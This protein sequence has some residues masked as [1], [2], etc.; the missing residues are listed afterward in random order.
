M[1]K[2]T[3][4]FLSETFS[5]GLFTFLG[6]VLGHAFGQTG[7]IIGA[8]MGGISGIVVVTILLSRVGLITIPHRKQAIVFGAATFI[9]AA[10][11]AVT[12]LNSPVIPLLSLLLVGTG[13]VFGNSY[14]AQEENKKPYRYALIGMVSLLPVFYFVAGSLVKYNLGVHHSFTLLDWFQADAMR[15]HYFNI[16]SPFIFTGGLSLGLVLNG[17]VFFN[18]PRL[19]ISFGGSNARLYKANLLLVIMSTLLL[20]TLVSYLLIENR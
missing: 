11:F 19:S 13:S 18:L 3:L 10:V 17:S 1:K 8:L 4:I 7:L 16:V 20:I 12:N 9:V 5:C 2:N 6:S 15:Q 14:S